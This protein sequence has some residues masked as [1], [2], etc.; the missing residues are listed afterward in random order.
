MRLKNSAQF[1][2]IFVA[3]S[4]NPLP[5][6]PCFSSCF[7]LIAR[8]F[9]NL[10]ILSGSVAACLFSSVSLSHFSPE[11]EDMVPFLRLLESFF[12]AIDPTE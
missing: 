8:S 3:V 10:T 12:D 4:L 6:A 2:A 7:P 1:V 11:A 9:N 5:V